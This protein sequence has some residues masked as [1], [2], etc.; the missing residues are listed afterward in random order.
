MDIAKRLK[1]NATDANLIACLTDREIE[2]FVN[3]RVSFLRLPDIELHLELCERC[4]GRLS[5]ASSDALVQ[6]LSKFQ[7]ANNPASSEPCQGKPFELAEDSRYQLLEELGCGGM[8]QVFKA[9]HK[10]MKR[11]VALKTIRPELVNNPEAVMRF[12]KEARG[13]ARLAHPN[14]VSAF[15]AER[16]GDV[17]F[18]VMEFVDGESL[19]RIVNRSGP[20]EPDVA[21]DYVRQA[22]L[23][24]QHAFEKGMVHR[25]IKP[26][27]L[28]LDA[29]GTVKI[30]DFGLS[31]IRRLATDSGDLDSVGD[32]TILTLT[33][34]RL[35]TEGYIA[36]EQA[37]DARSADI[38]SDVY[39][40]GCTL[41]FLLTKRPP[42]FASLQDD[43]TAIPDVTRF[44]KDL[45]P[46][47]IKVLA[48]MLHPDPAARFQTPSEVR[49]ALERV[50]FAAEQADSGSLQENPARPGPEKKGERPAPRTSVHKFRDTGALWIAGLIVI[51][52][53]LAIW[54]VFWV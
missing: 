48:R 53:L 38:R 44:R 8:G 32:E 47:L 49:T 31:R 1:V 10:L 15:D 11:V 45:P 37:R 33:N 26:Q 6:K 30:L 23:G 14:I 39:S 41:F 4:G 35:G 28:M 36:P 13:A 18:L 24:L 54:F 20:L 42:Y 43:P 40:L 16:E 29:D 22:A 7:F 2:D 34:T 51:L 19:N 17:H 50:D 25:D 3:G 21:A 12:A 27:N 5:A 46:D 9:R 52:V